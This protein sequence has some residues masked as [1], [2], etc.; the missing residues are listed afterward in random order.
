MTT[1]LLTLLQKSTSNL[2]RLGLLG[3]IAVTLPLAAY[4]QANAAYAAANIANSNAEGAA[5]AVT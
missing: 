4:A 1:S 2:I 3:T 5:N